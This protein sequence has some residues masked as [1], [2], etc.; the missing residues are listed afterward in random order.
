MV[1]VTD[2]REALLDYAR[3]MLRKLQPRVIGVTGSN[4]KSTTKEAIAAV[5]AERFQ[6]FKNFGS[7][8]GRYGLPIALGQ[9]ENQHEVAVLEMACDSFGEIAEMA[10]LT[11]PQIGVVTTVSPAHLTGLGSLD[12][13]ALEKG[14][15]I[16]QLPADGVAVLN[17]DD[18]R[19]LAM[20]QRTKAR[21]I[22]YGTGS[23]ADLRV[24]AIEVGSDWTRFTLLYQKRR[25]AGR[26]GLIGRHQIYPILAAIAVGLIFDIP[27][28]AALSRLTILPSLP[29]RMRLLRGLK[30]SLILDDSF[31]ASPASMQAALKTLALIGQG[32]KKMALLGKMADLGEAGSSRWP[33]RAWWCQSC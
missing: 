7:Y 11:R 32:K 9:L 33:N 1:L 3:Y 13:I 4:G 6:V 5:L 27:I 23:T 24:E 19:V 8:N 28:E 25:F 21:L 29:G 18:P 14:R 30:E 22:T 26:I 16:E 17:A 31:N 15:L 20:A 10:A 12:N 2:T